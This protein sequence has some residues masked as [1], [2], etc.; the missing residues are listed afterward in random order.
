[1]DEDMNIHIRILKLEG[2]VQ[3]WWDTHIESC[4]LVIKT[5]EPIATMPAHIIS[6]D[7]FFEELRD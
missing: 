3:A 2:I 4:P 5:G 1:M 7:G 6:W